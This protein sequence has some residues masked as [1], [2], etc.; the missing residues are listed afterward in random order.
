MIT[1]LLLAA[2]LLSIGPSIRRV[3]GRG[4]LLREGLVK[5]LDLLHD[6]RLGLELACPHQ[7]RR[8][9]C[10]VL[11]VASDPIPATCALQAEGVARA[12]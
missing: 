1:E 11:M 4:V 5:A 9:C 6:P 3:L 7:Q 8:H 10:V 12:A 2:D